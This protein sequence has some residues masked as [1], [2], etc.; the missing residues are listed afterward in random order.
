MGGARVHMGGAL[1]SCPYHDESCG[2]ELMF[3]GKMIVKT[4]YRFISIFIET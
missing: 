1:A 4:W 3:R 2:W